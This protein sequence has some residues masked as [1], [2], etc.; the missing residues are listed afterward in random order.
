MER[1]VERRTPPPSRCSC[2]ASGG[3]RRRLPAL[4]LRP[5]RARPP[6]EGPLARLAAAHTAWAG[7]RTSPIAAPSCIGSKSKRTEGEGHMGGRCGARP[8]Q[9]RLMAPASE[10]GPPRK[11]HPLPA[12]RRWCTCCPLATSK[13]ESCSARRG[14]PVAGQR[15]REQRFKGR[16]SRRPRRSRVNR[17]KESGG[18]CCCTSSAKCTKHVTLRDLVFALVDGLGKGMSHCVLDVRNNG[19][20]S[21]F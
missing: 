15:P 8:L 3:G 17:C 6:C 5:P 19:A 13:S 7:A 16:E 10:R 1:P 20:T 9:S 2:L 11:T 14:V 18:N 4:V 21:S 12:A